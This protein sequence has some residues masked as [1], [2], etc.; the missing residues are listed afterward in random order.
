MV[1][2]LA[3]LKANNLAASMAAKRVVHLVETLVG[4]LADMRVGQKVTLWAECLADCWADLKGGYL[5]KH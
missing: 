1:D 3:V 2:K 5:E 4:R